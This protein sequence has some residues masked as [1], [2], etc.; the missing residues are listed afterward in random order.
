MMIFL[1]RNR[2]RTGVWTRG[3]MDLGRTEAGS[4]RTH[5]EQ[6]PG[7]ACGS[8]LREGTDPH[9]APGRDGC[10][11]WRGRDP[12]SALLRSGPSTPH[13]GARVEGLEEAAKSTTLKAGV[14]TVRGRSLASVLWTLPPTP[15]LSQQAGKVG[16]GPADVGARPRCPCAPC[17]PPSLSPGVIIGDFPVLLEGRPVASGGQGTR[18]HHVPVLSWAR[19]S[20]LGLKRQVMATLRGV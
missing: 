8:L 12:P 20:L 3:R 18:G 16:W 14:T 11:V 17:F 6:G 2:K 15:N 9:P 5:R 1:Q 19:P 4:W 13:L 7:T 10:G